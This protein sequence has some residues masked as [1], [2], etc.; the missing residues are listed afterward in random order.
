[1]QIKEACLIFKIF[2]PI[3]HV[4]LEREREEELRLMKQ[5]EIKIFKKLKIFK[6]IQNNNLTEILNWLG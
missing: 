5:G 6:T 4:T 3:Y 2:R 1:M